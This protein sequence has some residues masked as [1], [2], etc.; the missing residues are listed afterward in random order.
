MRHHARP[1][2]HRYRRD[3]HLLSALANSPL[4]KSTPGLAWE[5]GGGGTGGEERRGRGEALSRCF[6][7]PLTANRHEA[8][9]FLSVNYRIA[10]LQAAE[11]V[12]AELGFSPWHDR[13]LTCSGRLR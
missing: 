9:F 4:K 5:G 7:A 8:F 12:S 2:S 13:V 6:F 11:D 1:R 10:C 3:N